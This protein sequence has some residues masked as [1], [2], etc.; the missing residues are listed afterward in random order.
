[1]QQ[2]G[3][4]L[5]DSGA[6]RHSPKVTSLRL[7]VQDIPR[8]QPAAGRVGT[9]G[10]ETSQEVAGMV[11]QGEQEG[12]LCPWAPHTRKLGHLRPVA[13]VPV[14]I[15]AVMLYSTFENVTGK[16]NLGGSVG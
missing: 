9:K 11:T 7:Q 4:P 1:M 2:P 12:P 8:G 16:G 6:E 14:E 15:L 3:Q 13:R 5:G 10:E